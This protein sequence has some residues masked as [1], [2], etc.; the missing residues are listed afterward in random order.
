MMLTGHQASRWPL[1]EA[2]LRSFLGQTY[3]PRELIIVNQ[4]LG[5]AFQRRL[6]PQ[7]LDES[8]CRIREIL[9]KR[10]ATLGEARNVAL[11]MAEGQWLLSWDDDDWSHPTRIAWQ[12]AHRRPNRAVAFT[13]RIHYSFVNRRA[14]VWHDSSTA[15]AD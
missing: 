2:S 13:S 14:F 7:D 10:P 11:E 4:S 8:G 9:I 15:A 5:T 6:I 3:R 1:A 12:M